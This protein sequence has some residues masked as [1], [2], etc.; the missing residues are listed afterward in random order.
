MRDSLDFGGAVP[1]AID[2]PGAE[3]PPAP[4]VVPRATV[5]QRASTLS[6]PRAGLHELPLSSESIAGIAALLQGDDRTSVLQ[7]DGIEQI[8]ANACAARATG[9]L[10]KLDSELHFTHSLVGRVDE[11]QAM[12]AHLHSGFSEVVGRTATFQKQCNTLVEQC[13]AAEKMGRVVQ[14]NVSVYTALSSVARR[15]HA[16]PPSFVTQREFAGIVDQINTGIDFMQEHKS[17]SSEADSFLHKYMAQQSRAIG[18]IAAYVRNRLD[19]AQGQIEEEMGQQRQ[20]T[21]AAIKVYVYTRFETLV[22]EMGTVLRLVDSNVDKRLDF[23]TLYE[24]CLARYFSVR[25]HLLRGFIAKSVGEIVSE[26]GGATASRVRALLLL[27]HEVCEEELTL[28]RRFFPAR[29][30][31]G[32]EKSF[33]TIMQPVSDAARSLVPLE[34]SIDA[35]CDHV[36]L[37]RTLGGPRDGMR[38]C[39]LAQ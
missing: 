13:E 35:L 33:S 8:V 1:E 32:L 4:V 11:L 17:L 38:W 18:L 14:E 26:D 25:T 27:A 21:K 16:P 19:Y 39:V 22:G 3:P 34:A 5:R 6:T 23:K 9:M 12:L 30:D 28:C 24:D 15:L 7:R 29:A 31:T 36:S 2:A 10:G 37:I 20:L